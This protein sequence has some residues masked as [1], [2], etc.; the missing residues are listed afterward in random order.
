MDTWLI[1]KIL[2]SFVAVA[3]ALGP[4]RADFNRTHATNPSWTSHARFHVVWQV[5]L[6][7]GVSIAVLTLLWASE[8]RVQTW[9]ALALTANWILT[10]FV[11]VAAMPRFE[12][13]LA[14]PGTGIE[15]FRFSFGSRHLEVDTNLFGACVLS[16]I[17]ITAALLLAAS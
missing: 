2:I 11:T 1:G 4:M 7:A 8:G 15:P 9:I 16:L 14:D 12:G 5:L 6:Q 3:Q 10:F 13:T 17:V